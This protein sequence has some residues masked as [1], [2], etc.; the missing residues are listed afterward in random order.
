ML[1]PAV[2]Q[3]APWTRRELMGIGLCF[4]GLSIE[5]MNVMS[6]AESIR[7]GYHT[8]YYRPG[9]DWE[10]ADL[11]VKQRLEIVNRRH[12]KMCLFDVV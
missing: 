12:Q 9:S 5:A 3:A 11:L 7:K 10:R 4:F 6:I 8:C 2:A 1:P